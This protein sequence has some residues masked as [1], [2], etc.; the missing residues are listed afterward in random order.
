ML[1]DLKEYIADLKHLKKDIS[2]ESTKTINKQNLRIRAEQ[3]SRDWFAKY[4][5]RIKNREIVNIEIL[6]EYDELFER[7]LRLSSPSNLKQSYLDVLTN[8]LKNINDRLILPISMN[9]I[10]VSGRE[11]SELMGDYENIIE[12]DY[13]KEA[14]ECANQGFNR[15]GA[16]LGWSACV[17]RIHKKIENIGFDVFNNTSVTLSDKREGRFKRF[18]K[19]FNISSSNEL[20][21]VF[22]TDLLW[23]IEG[24]ELIDLNEHKRLRSCF[25][26]RC[27][28]AHPGNAPITK[29]NLLSFF[30]DIREIVLFNEKFRV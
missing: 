4:K 24:L 25:D 11:F 6:S 29:Y 21:E 2:K 30:S 23:I 10:E 7:L 17:F 9:P 8:I 14:I 12:Y 28:S 1:D 5:E 3:I 20:G 18:N 16:V 26:L 15:A 22:D 13:L 19:K 27:Q